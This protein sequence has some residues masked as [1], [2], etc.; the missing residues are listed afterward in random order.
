MEKKSAKGV[1]QL[2]PL[3]WYSLDRVAADEPSQG[4]SQ[5][6]RKFA[7]L[8]PNGRWD[9]TCRSL[10]EKVQWLTDIQV[11]VTKFQNKI[12]H[13]PLEAALRLCEETCGK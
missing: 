3:E 9:V 12:F 7:I 11:S 6:H 5:I 1:P 8:V 4:T 2:H 13:V 10:E